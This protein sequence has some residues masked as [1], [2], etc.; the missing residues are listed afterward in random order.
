MVD[1][2]QLLTL[3]KKII[4]LSDIWFLSH[5][6]RFLTLHDGRTFP[7][8]KLSDSAHDYLGRIKAVEERVLF[9]EGLSPEYFLG[10]VSFNFF[11]FPSLLWSSRGQEVR[12][13]NHIYAWVVWFSPFH[14]S[15]NHT[16]FIAISEQ[17]LYARAVPECINMGHSLYPI[18]ILIG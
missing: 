6:N 17:L 4:S 9:L 3:C 11:I 2:S 10:G 13:G 15:S 16:V 14:L 5:T 8:F 1:L 7:P 18:R 12:K